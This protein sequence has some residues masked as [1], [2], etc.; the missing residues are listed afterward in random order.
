MEAIDFVAISDDQLDR[1]V[2]GI[3]SKIGAMR[4][5]QMAGLREI[6]RRQTPLA[7]G[8]RSMVEWVTGRLDISPDTAKTLIF[9][10]R[11]L[12]D[13]PA[14]EEAAADGHLTDDRT[15]AV[16]RLAQPGDGKTALTESAGL[17]V[18]GIHRQVALHRRMTRNQ[19]HQG[20]RDRYVAT[21]SNL[22]HTARDFHGHM[23]G[24]ASREFEEALHSVGDQLPDTPGVRRSRG[25]RNADA[26]WKMA[27]DA[28]A[29]HDGAGAAST[30]G[31]TVFVDANQ[32]AAS[33]AETGVVIES[34]P[35]VGPATLEAVICSGSIEVTAVTQ[36]GTPLNIGRRSRV[37]SPKLRRYVLHRDGGACTAD[38]CTSRYR[39]EAHHITPWSQGGRT[40]ADNL[41]TL[42]WYHHHVIIHGEGFSIDPQSPACRRRFVRPRN[43]DPP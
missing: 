2:A 25:T 39:L 31:V 24:I 17:D 37:V 35:R 12:E 19:E 42:C 9:T 8:C 20:F 15:V 41:T 23:V 3:E 22:D 36:D 14:V 5:A 34:G 18:A 1:F 13:L 38:G 40:D 11:S 6:D 7:D 4:T 28:L 26:L 32:A 16:A 43:H 29:G 21:Q 30:H 27:H 10:A 33:N